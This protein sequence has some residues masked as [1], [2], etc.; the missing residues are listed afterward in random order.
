MN[1]KISTK[2]IFATYH[3]PLPKAQ[4]ETQPQSVNFMAKPKI[5]LISRKREMGHLWRSKCN[6]GF[7]NLNWT[8]KWNRQCTDEV[9]SDCHLTFMKQSSFL[10]VLD[11]LKSVFYKI[12][13]WIWYF[14]LIFCLF[15]LDFYCLCSLQKSSSKINFVK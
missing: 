6:F 10:F 5:A 7:M 9:T 14:K 11:Y 8:P 3:E 12:E 1:F 4:F 13:F 2:A 15:Q